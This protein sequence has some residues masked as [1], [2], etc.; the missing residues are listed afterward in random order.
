MYYD[1]LQSGENAKPTAIRFEEKA[2]ADD[3]E[4]GDGDGEITLQELCRENIDPDVY[5]PSGLPGS[6]IGDF[7]IS[8]ARTIGHFRGEGECTTKRIDPVPTGV[9][10]P[11]Q[12]YP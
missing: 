9:A 11:C 1:S 6:T 5:N 3:G 8:L 4:N 12:E 10:S 2:R 7:V